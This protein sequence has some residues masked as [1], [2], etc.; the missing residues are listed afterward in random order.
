M[1]QKLPVP[2]FIDPVFAKISPKRSFLVIEN[3]R[4]G[5]VFAKTGSVNSG[6][7]AE[8]ISF[9]LSYTHIGSFM[10][11]LAYAVLQLFCSFKSCKVINIVNSQLPLQ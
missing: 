5:H 9:R 3:E 4:F 7:D 8:L 10:S 11:L 6:T 1:N 2:E